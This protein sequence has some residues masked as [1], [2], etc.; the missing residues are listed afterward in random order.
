MHNTGHLIFILIYLLGLVVVG[1]FLGK[2]K[3]KNSDDFVV[4]GRK[5]PLLVL[6]GTLLATWVGGG[7]ITG[8]ANMTY[9]NG[10][11]VG[12]LYFI[13]APIGIILL[14]FI[15]GKVRK[16]EK[17]TVA[18]IIEMKYGTV[19]RTISAVCI[20]LAYIGIVSYQFKGGG[21]VLNLTTGMNIEA[22]TLIS[23][24]VII[25]LAVSGGMVT[26]A[27][28]DFL[29]ALL[30]VISMSI[31]IPFILSDVGGWSNL[32][33]QIPKDKMT[34][35]GGMTTIQL[36]GYILPLIFLILGDQNMFQRFSSAKDSKTASRSNIGFFVGEI[37]II[38]L[39]VTFATAAIIMFPNIK[40]DTAILQVAIGGVPFI[41]GG[42]ILAAAVAFMVTTGDSF[43]M[44]AATNITYDFWIKFIKPNAT[45]Q[46]KLKFT[47]ITIIVLGVFSYI[48]G[49]YFPS[50]LS[51]QMY[52]Y[53]MY[54]AAI[55]PAFLAAI[56]WKKATKYG[57][58]FSIIVGGGTTLIWEIFLNK[59]LGWNGILIAG[60][61]AILTLIIVSLLTQ[62]NQRLV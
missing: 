55:T 59:P 2:R 27:Y 44:S 40:P 56:L 35:T 49:R 16:L 62:K 3:I 30:I 4:A 17:Y 23:A 61:L 13:G 47:K 8:S 39:A 6:V 58:L 42:I 52:S 5:L 24:A 26:I 54:G 1:I 36:L 10:P 53:T 32:F 22:G 7:V 31:G 43:L 48:I 60:P 21:Y 57:G 51:M 50:I 20:V 29:S 34:W 41:L 45:E 12:V 9:T 37:I 28:S 14:F 46:E 25:T 19:A 11:F 15:A 33:S 38:F 18:E